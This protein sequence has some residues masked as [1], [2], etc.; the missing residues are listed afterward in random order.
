M[1]GLFGTRALVASDLNLLL[2]IIVLTIILIGIKFAR[3]KTEKS[4]K[5]HGTLMTLA[6]ILNLIGL[7]TVMLPSFLSKIVSP[8]TPVHAFFGGISEIL[9]ITFVFKKFGN[10]R[11]WM[12]LTAI[13]WLIALTLGI[14]VYLIYY[15]I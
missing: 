6:M 9:G 1:S 12:R 4:L 13:F 15:V 5:K 7:A 2:Q 3:T 10:V 14:T 11:M 8:L